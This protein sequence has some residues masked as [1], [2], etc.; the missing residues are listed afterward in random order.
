MSDSRSHI[1]Y[2]DI[3]LEVPIINEILFLKTFYSINFLANYFFLDYVKVN[4]NP[5]FI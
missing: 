3:R 1:V 5:K 2:S 4:I